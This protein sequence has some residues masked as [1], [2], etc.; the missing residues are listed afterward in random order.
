LKTI[1]RCESSYILLHKKDI[2][3]DFKEEKGLTTAF[4]IENGNL[5]FYKNFRMV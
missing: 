4:R 5:N 3:K 2:C 1:F